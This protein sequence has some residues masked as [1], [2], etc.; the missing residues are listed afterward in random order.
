MGYGKDADHVGLHGIDQREAKSPE[1]LP[2]KNFRSSQ[3]RPSFRVLE[4]EMHACLNLKG[5]VASHMRVH[6]SEPIE[7]G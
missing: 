4:E 6:R 5:E 2:A 3:R 7:F 1:H